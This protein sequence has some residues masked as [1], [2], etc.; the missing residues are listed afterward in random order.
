[1]KH[2]N[3]VFALAAISFFTLC[4]FNVQPSFAGKKA[5]KTINDAVKSASFSMIK[6]IEVATKKF[7]AKPIRVDVAPVAKEDLKRWKAH[8]VY[9]M[10]L[11]SAKGK[12]ISVQVHMNSGKI[13]GHSFPNPKQ[14]KK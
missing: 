8:F 6:A 9:Q 13:L 10:D 11:L 3:R 4:L 5:P 7:K 1:M 2:L 12:I 14:A